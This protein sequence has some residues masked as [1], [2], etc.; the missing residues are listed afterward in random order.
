MARSRQTSGVKPLPLKALALGLALGA[1]A[2][3][4]RADNALHGRLEVQEVAAFA[5]SDSI[6]AA[7]GARDRNDA[8]ANLRLTWEPSWDRWSFAA[9][10][11]IGF[12][13]G[14]G[15]RLARAEAGLVPTPPATWFNLTNTFEDHGQLSASQ[16]L[17]RLSLSY[18]TTY[19]VFRLGRQALTWGSGMVFRPMDLFDPFSPDATDTEYKP[20]TD[21]AYL[22][23]LFDDG[24]DLQA[25]YVPRP[26]KKGSAP[27]ANASSFAVHYHATL[28]GYQTTLMAARDHGDWTGAIGVNGALGGATWNLEFVP[29]LVRRG[30]ARFSGIANISDAVTLFGRDATVYLEYFHNGF[31][32]RGAYDFTS[33]PAD[34]MD[35]LGRGQVFNTRQNYLAGGMSLMATPLLTLDPTL[36]SCLDDGSL[37]AILS[38]TYSLSDNLNLIAGVQ[39]PIG[40]SGSEF[41]GM[42]FPGGLTFAP[43]ARLYVQLRQYF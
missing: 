30:A 2:L 4:A 39:A 41:G 16:R 7:F 36:I 27:A 21:M 14:D 10:Y 20:G 9:N 11:I 31:G 8:T 40:P 26:A 3:P 38:G 12:D 43:P 32:A 34:L 22:Q 33:L 6:D 13:V 37:Y 18:T 5:R 1:A 29:T 35:R 15:A 25:I 23:V 28:F 24:S 19:T 17:D 42:P